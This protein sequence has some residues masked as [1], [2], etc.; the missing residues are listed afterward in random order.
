[1][2][3][4][5]QIAAYLLHVAVKFISKNA[6]LQQVECEISERYQL[7]SVNR[8]EPFISTKVITA[9]QFPSL[10]FFPYKKLSGT[11]TFCRVYHN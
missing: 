10:E 3:R 4:P 2:T 7:A 11:T 5:S 1:M 8:F 9:S 6:T